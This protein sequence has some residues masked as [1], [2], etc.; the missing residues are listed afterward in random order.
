MHAPPSLIWQLLHACPSLMYQVQLL[1]KEQL[2]KAALET[3]L[4]DMAQD[5]AAKQSALQ[6]LEAS[7]ALITSP[8]NQQLT[9]QQRNQL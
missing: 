2:V 5:I 7:Y 6:S 3:Q 1:E 8:R 4:G 9:N